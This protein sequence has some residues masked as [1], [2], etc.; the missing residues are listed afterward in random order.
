L[1]IM[2]LICHQNQIIFKNG[3]FL[4]CE[5]QE[6]LVE[7]FVK[8]WKLS[9]KC[10]HNRIGFLRLIGFLPF[11][12]FIPLTLFVHL[13]GHIIWKFT[14]IRVFIKNQ[15]RLKLNVGWNLYFF[16]NCSLLPIKFFWSACIIIIYIEGSEI[17]RW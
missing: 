11:E 13:K 10:D 5:A 8:A 9:L 14:K 15:F 16:E 7:Y 12:D 2:V 1:H 17:F 6:I 4:H 3:N